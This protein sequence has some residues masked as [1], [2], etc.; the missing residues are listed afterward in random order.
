[1]EGQTYLQDLEELEEDVLSLCDLP[2]NDQ[3]STESDPFPPTYPC[4]PSRPELFEFS[5]NPNAEMKP[6]ID[7]I[8]FC[9][10]IMHQKEVSAYNL[11]T[12]S[13]WRSESLNKAHIMH[14]IGFT[15]TIRSNSLRVP[16][17]KPD[18]APATGS[19][20][21]PDSCSRKH[22]VFIGPVKIRPEMEL[23][24]IRKRQG[25]R[26]PVP[27]FPVV[28]GDESVIVGGK[29]GGGRS[30]WGLLRPLRCRSHLASVLARAFGCVPTRVI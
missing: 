24:E 12:K 8:I 2:I 15:N 30:H 14:S 7:T 3:E 10:R 17:P 21:H 9:G 28:G 4:S 29:S 27:M 19:Y 6:E 1:M 5:T 16:G 18:T 23:S 11:Q 25:R 26:A 13:K 20:R 22:K